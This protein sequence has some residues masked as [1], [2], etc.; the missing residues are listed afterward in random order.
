MLQDTYMRG[1][2]YR[3]GVGRLWYGSLVASCNIG[4]ICLRD[5]TLQVNPI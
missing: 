5:A 3:G 4:S 1:D 2:P